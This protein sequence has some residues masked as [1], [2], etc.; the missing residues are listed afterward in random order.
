MS[1]SETIGAL[2]GALAKAQGSLGAAIKDYE[3]E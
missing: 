3:L 2:A 1:Q